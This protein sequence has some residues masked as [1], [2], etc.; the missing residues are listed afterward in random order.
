MRGLLIGLVLMAG[1]AD[2]QVM[3]RPPTNVREFALPILERVTAEHPDAWACAHVESRSCKADWINLAASALHAANPRFGLNGKRGNPADVSMD[4]ITYL[5][6]P[7]N[8]RM[9]AAWDVCGGC[10]ASGARVVFNEI[11]NYAT[12][13]QPGTAIWLQPNPATGGGGNGGG[14]GTVTPPPAPVDLA[15]VLA[16]LA[17]LTAKVDAVAALALAGRDAALDAKAEAEQ[18]K[19]NA[20]D[21]LHTAIPAL[22]TLIEQAGLSGCLV[23]RVP[24]AFGGSTEVRFCP[25]P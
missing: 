16:A 17:S 24:K 2:A 8:P 21:I 11:T 4:V 5:L 18:A 14:G 23:G 10:G 6:D 20:S 19:V 13:G 15:P 1:T 7:S 22:R 9:V 3:T 25:A 12:I